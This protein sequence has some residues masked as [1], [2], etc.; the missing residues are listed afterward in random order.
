MWSQAS[1]EGSR[2]NKKNN[3]NKTSSEIRSVPEFRPNLIL[4]DAALSFFWRELPQQEE[5]QEQD[6]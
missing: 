1:F 5:Q 6:E 3:K 2:P 4:N